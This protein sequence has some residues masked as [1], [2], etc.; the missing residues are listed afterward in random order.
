[1]APHLRTR[2]RRRSSSSVVG[3][4]RSPSVV[5]KVIEPAKNATAE[6]RIAEKVALPASPAELSRLLARPGTQRDDPLRIAALLDVQR[7]RGNNAVQ[8]LLQRREAQQR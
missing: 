1:M 8:R 3:S 6:G 4:R 5:A 2:L 7:S